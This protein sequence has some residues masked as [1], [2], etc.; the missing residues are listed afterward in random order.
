[1]KSFCVKKELFW[2]EIRGPRK[3]K[4]KSGK[5]DPVERDYLQRTIIAQ[6]PRGGTLW[7]PGRNSMEGGKENLKAG[8]GEERLV[9][10]RK[11][12]IVVDRSRPENRR[13]GKIYRRNIKGGDLS[14]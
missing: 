8:G 3:Y 6:P 12:Q 5:K 4:I 14:Q 1:M 13:I 10:R 7:L 11:K 9:N 2:E